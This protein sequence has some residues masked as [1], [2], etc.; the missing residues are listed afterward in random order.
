MR[1]TLLVI[2]CI[3][4]VF[5]FGQKSYSIDTLLM[6]SSFTFTVISES[7]AIAE[8]A[9]KEAIGE[10][11]RIEN[12]I[13]SWRDDSE[14]AKI[15]ANAGVHPVKVT[16]ELFELIRRSKKISA[17]SRGNFDISFAALNGLWNF[18]GE[19]DAVPTQEKIDKYLERVNY[20]KI[21]LKHEDT[22]VFL[23]DEGMKIG[24][25]AIGKG[26][27]ANRARKVL[28]G[29]GITSGVVNAGGDLIGSVT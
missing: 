2:V 18:S 3:V 9:L 17:L 27:A 22:S 25:G 4:Q 8:K 12:A 11:I 14:T 6:G 28:T 20:D 13:S 10:V 1:I 15:N 19:Q 16:F 21:T 5:A 7:N 23:K 24:F 29:H 26:Y